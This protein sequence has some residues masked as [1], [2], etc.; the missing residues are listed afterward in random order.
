MSEL[1]DKLQKA[2]TAIYIA[3]E[4]PVAKDISGLLIKAKEEITRLS[5]EVEK[6]YRQGHYDGFLELEIEWGF[7]NFKKHMKLREVGD[8]RQD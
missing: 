6:A 8:E 3:V 1:I 5:G 4:E 7:D 2:S